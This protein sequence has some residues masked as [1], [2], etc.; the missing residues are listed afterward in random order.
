[1]DKSSF[2]N[3]VS[4]LKR[5]NKFVDDLSDLGINI[6]NSQFL[7]DTFYCVDKVIEQSFDVV[8]KDTFFAWFYE[9]I[10]EQTE[11][12]ITYKFTEDPVT[13]WEFLQYHLA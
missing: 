12:G 4:R 2:I 8:G 1:M 3:F 6:L 10:Y 11:N 5:I 13:V 7:E 9:D